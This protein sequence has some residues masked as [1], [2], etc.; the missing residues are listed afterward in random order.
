M[1]SRREVLATGLAMGVLG[2]RAWAQVLPEGTVASSVMDALPGKRPLIKRAFRPP[3]Y[4]TP[5]NLFDQLYTPNDAFFV[6]WHLADIPTVDPGKWRLKVGG[7]GAERAGEFTLDQL[8]RSFEVI[9]IAAVCQCSGNRRGFS[10]PHVAGVEWGYGAMGNAKWRGVRF[11]DVLDRMGLRKE[12][13]EVALN[14]SDAG[15]VEKTPDFIKSIPV[16]KA[17]DPDTL[18]AFEM[19]G[20]P[21]PHWNGA[22]ARLVVPGWTATYWVKQLANVEVRTQ[23]FD[24]FWMAKA[25]RIPRTEF[26]VVQRFTTQ[27]AAD[28]TPITEMMVNSVITNLQEGQK[29]AAGK[30]VSVQG[31][32]WDGG[33][34]IRSVEVS[35][36]GGKTWVPADLGPD[37]G[38]YA[39]RQWRYE[40]KPAQGSLT[41]MARASNRLGQTQTAEALWNAAGY[42]HNVMQ[43]ITVQ[44]G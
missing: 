10:Q 17:L 40:F 8:K 28:S 16:W 6:R 24:G 22:P 41:V 4:E 34:G 31:V 3:N 38:R 43:K 35:S 11:K 42:H 30:P 44:V 23:P 9:E 37:I 33:Y 7:D 20:E 36:D 25:Y 5:V 18:I 21:L 12:A 32:A 14:G 2:R 27:E 39:W 15:V 29:V 19:N 13:V 1:P 26:P